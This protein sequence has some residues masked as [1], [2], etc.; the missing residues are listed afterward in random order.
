MKPL[1]LILI[2]LGAIAIAYGITLQIAN[3]PPNRQI[4]PSKWAEGAAANYN[5]PDFT[6][7][8]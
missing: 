2:P 4:P 7:T 1:S 5:H 6:E 3:R 8:R